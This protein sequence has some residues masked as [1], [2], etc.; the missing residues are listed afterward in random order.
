M[1][2]SLGM[3]PNLEKYPIII[4]DSENNTEERLCKL[5]EIKGIDNQTSG[6]QR[7][8]VEIG[9]LELS[10]SVFYREPPSSL[11]VLYP[12]KK[13]EYFQGDSL[14]EPD[15]GDFICEQADGRREIIRMADAYVENFDTTKV[16]DGIAK[17]KYQGIHCE[18]AI[19]VL[20]RILS[21]IEITSKKK[22]HYIPGESYDK[23][24]YTVRAKYAN[25]SEE[26]IEN[27]E[28]DKQIVGK[29]DKFLSFS[30]KGF[31][32]SIP[33]SVDF[34]KVESL[35]LISPPTKT[36]YI[37]GTESLDCFGGF[38]EV[39]YS[40]GASQKIQLLNE[41]TI[42]YSPHKLGQQIITI[43]YEHLTTFFTVTIKENALMQ[44]KVSR[45]PKTEYIEGES[46]QRAGLL[47]YACYE[48]GEQF[49]ITES[50]TITPT[51]PLIPSDSMMAILF[52][53]L[54]AIIPITV[55]QK[56]Q[57]NVPTAS[58][59]FSHWEEPPE[60]TSKIEGNA[61]E[62]VAEKQ[63]EI[64]I[65]RKQESIK[66][67]QTEAYQKFKNEKMPGYV[68]VDHPWESY[69]FYSSTLSL[70]FDESEMDNENL[71]S[72]VVKK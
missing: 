19:T 15:G 12:P 9:G 30:Y 2:L 67:I 11:T 36:D 21:K 54:H 18:V 16:G 52:D 63:V 51:R 26:I 65:A 35:I 56:A 58:F 43:K 44:L 42:G 37:L 47:V 10:F 29:S 53:G 4:T 20:E 50:A 22:S 13:T 32:E 71:P 55:L 57:E 41:H 70:R 62:I 27:Y 24:D 33:I 72:I 6:K 66:R 7:G 64:D 40:S 59:D 46:F 61:P 23:S 34:D 38:L 69:E 31:S 60:D 45:P 25:N 49:D 5:E 17:L 3:F 8:V 39:T 28:F 1:P 68:W 48:N 14:F